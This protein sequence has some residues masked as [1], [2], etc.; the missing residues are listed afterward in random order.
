MTALQNNTTVVVDRYAASGACYSAAKGLGLDWC[1]APDVG[2]PAPDLTVYLRAESTDKLL[3]DRP[4]FGDERYETTVFQAK[5]ANQF[6]RLYELDQVSGSPTWLSVD[7]AQ[8]PEEVHTAIW[9]TVNKVVANV[10]PQINT[11][12]QHLNSVKP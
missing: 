6:D 7:A 2:L 10:K 1:C 8:P 11:L 9:Q 12:W 5:V 3:K 4:G